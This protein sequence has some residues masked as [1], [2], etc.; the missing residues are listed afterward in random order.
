[1]AKTKDYYDDLLFNLAREAASYGNT[2]AVQGLGARMMA[3]DAEWNKYNNGTI[4]YDEVI[5]TSE[6]IVDSYRNIC[7]H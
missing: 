4:S 7:M 1:M 2:K 6:R 3:I 5:N